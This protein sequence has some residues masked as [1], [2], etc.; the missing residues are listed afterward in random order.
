MKSD[1][2]YTDINKIIN[3]PYL[4]RVYRKKIREFISKFKSNLNNSLDINIL[5]TLVTEAKEQIKRE[6]R[7]VIYI[8][9]LTNKEKQEYFDSQK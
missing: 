1:N 7:E 5:D 3:S 4:S 8:S 2:Q 9:T 6:K